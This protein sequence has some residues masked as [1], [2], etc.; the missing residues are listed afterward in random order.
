[1]NDICRA[2]LIN[3]YNGQLLEDMKLGLVLNII[4]EYQNLISHKNLFRECNS[5]MQF[6]PLH[7][8]KYV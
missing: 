2:S 7:F 6:F 8:N 5:T 4:C 3:G 1:M